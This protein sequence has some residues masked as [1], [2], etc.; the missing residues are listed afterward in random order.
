MGAPMLHQEK[1][2]L[3]ERTVPAG[4]QTASS[5]RSNFD[6]GRNA[7]CTIFVAKRDAAGSPI[8]VR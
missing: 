3:M 2:M 8:A 7:G 4:R 1:P 6:K 5:Q